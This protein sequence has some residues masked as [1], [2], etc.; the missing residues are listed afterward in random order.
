LI[1]AAVPQEPL[2]GPIGQGVMAALNAAGTPGPATG[3]NCFLSESIK[4]TID[5]AGGA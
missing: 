5:V 2:L 1:N 3:N 4:Q